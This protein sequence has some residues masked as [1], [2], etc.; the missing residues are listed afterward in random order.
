MAV[1]A[2]A[3]RRRRSPWRSRCARGR[4]GAGP[5]PGRWAPWRR[6]ALIGAGLGLL[7]VLD[8]SVSWTAGAVPGARAAAVDVAASGPATTCVAS[9]R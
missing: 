2:A 6:G 7:L 3:P 5:P 9:S 1:L 8:P 4:A